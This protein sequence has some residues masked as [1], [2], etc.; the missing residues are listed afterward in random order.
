MWSATGLWIDFEL[1]HETDE[2][3]MCSNWRATLSNKKHKTLYR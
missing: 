2:E 1:V 3:A